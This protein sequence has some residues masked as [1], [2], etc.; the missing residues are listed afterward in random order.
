MAQEREHLKK[1]ARM[2]RQKQNTTMQPKW[3]KTHNWN[4]SVD[5]KQNG[6]RE[7]QLINE[8]RRKTGRAR[9]KSARSE[10]RDETKSAKK[11]D[12]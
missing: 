4:T 11:V 12:I 6:R 5:G 1:R 8:K 9:T 7:E 3:E 10:M 2:A